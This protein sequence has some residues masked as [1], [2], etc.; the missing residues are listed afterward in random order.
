[1]TPFYERGGVTIWNQDCRDV[2]PGLQAG[3]ATLVVTDPPYGVDKAAWDG[4]FPTFWIA[5][6]LRIA[7][8]VLCMSGSAA[9]IQAGSAFG[10]AYRDV[11]CLNATNGMTRSPIAFGNWFPVIAAGDWKW[12]GRPSLIRFSVSTEEEIDHPSP[13]PIQAMRRLLTYF[14]KPEDVILDPF[15]GSGTT[16]RAAKD[17]GRRAIGIEINEAYCEIAANRL[18]Q[19]VMVFA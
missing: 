15:M 1:M 11:I 17:L 18:R 14:S 10:S 4:V 7:G 2:L 3:S 16:L 13:K 5:D 6:A 19:E 9:L 8:R 12:D